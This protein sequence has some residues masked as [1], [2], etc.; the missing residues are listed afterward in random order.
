[1]RRGSGRLDRVLRVREVEED[2]ARGA[3]AVAE[4][5]ASRARQRTLDLVAEHRAALEDLARR[6]SEG[7]ISPGQA[8]CA[9]RT[10]DLIAKEIVASKQRERRAAERAERARAPW[11]NKRREKRGLELL[12]ERARMARLEE[13]RAAEA[14]GMDEVAIQRAAREK[15]SEEDRR[16]PE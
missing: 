1:M 13:A 6:Q 12:V 11:E 8:L 10:I 9:H 14:A 5:E 7:G 15:R 4:A 2:V 3:W 16:N